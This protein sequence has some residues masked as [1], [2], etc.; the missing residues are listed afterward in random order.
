MIK[1]TKI[2]SKETKN[3]TV[4]EI[5]KCTAKIII[6]K[7]LFRQNQFNTNKIE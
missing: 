1:I 2:N 7:N 5:N 4:T 3:S 6:F